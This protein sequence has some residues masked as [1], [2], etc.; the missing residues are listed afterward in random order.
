MTTTPTPERDDGEI[1]DVAIAIS[2]VFQSGGAGILAISSAAID[3]LDAY[4]AA[5]APKVEA[6]DGSHLKSLRQ[7]SPSKRKTKDTHGRIG[8]RCVKIKRLSMTERKTTPA[9]SRI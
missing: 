9:Q 8:E 2:G 5:H 4:R 7:L 6:R 1:E 3:R